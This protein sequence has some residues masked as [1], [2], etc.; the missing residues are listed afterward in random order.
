MCDYLPLDCRAIADWEPTLVVLGHCLRK[1]QRYSAAAS[2][3][4]QA[5]ALQPYSSGTLSALGYCCQL[6]GVRACMRACVRAGAP[7]SAAAAGGPAGVVS[8]AHGELYTP[9]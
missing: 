9:H 5:L 6:T 8:A 4:S 7:G 1:L 3:Y 2:Y